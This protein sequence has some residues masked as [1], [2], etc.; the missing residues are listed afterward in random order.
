MRHRHHEVSAQRGVLGNLWAWAH[1]GPTCQGYGLGIPST[2]RH[3]SHIDKAYP[4]VH[5]Q[6]L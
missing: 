1:E 6:I 3:T 2:P 4:R 5:G